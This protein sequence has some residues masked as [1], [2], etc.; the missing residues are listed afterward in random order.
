MSTVQDGKLTVEQLLLSVKQLSP[1]ELREFTRQFWVWQEQKGAQVLQS[2]IPRNGAEEAALLACIGENSR[3]PVME[4]RCYERL[5][6]KFERRMLTEH[7]LAEYQSL[8]QQLE[9]RNVKRIEALIILA[10][11]RGTTLRGIMAELG[12]KEVDDVL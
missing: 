12:L 7:E 4:Q 3:L 8:L 9:A 1:T 6:R 2:E 11:W 5:R 10:Q